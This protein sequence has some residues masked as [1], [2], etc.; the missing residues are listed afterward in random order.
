MISIK[1][2]FLFYSLCIHICIALSTAVKTEY[3]EWK[4]LNNPDDSPAHT[5]D[6]EFDDK[7]VQDTTESDKSF[8]KATEIVTENDLCK[9]LQCKPHQVCLLE[10]DDVAVCISKRKLNAKENAMK[11]SVSKKPKTKELKTESLFWEKGEKEDPVPSE[12]PNPC[13]PCPV[14]KPDFVC[15]S[16]NHTYSSVCRLEFRNCMHKVSVKVNCKGFCP[17]KTIKN[18]VDKSKEWQMKDR[19]NRYM[20]KYQNTVK[21]PAAVQKAL[22]K[23]HSINKIV[24]N[25]NILSNKDVTTISTDTMQKPSK[26]FQS[27]KISTPI[28]EKSC[29]ENELKAMGDRLLDWF[30]VVMADHRRGQSRR[31]SFR[32]SHTQLPDCKPEVSWMFQ[33]LD[34]DGDLKLSLQELYDLENDDQEH[35]LRPYLLDCDVERD[36]VLSPY[37]WCSCFDKSQRPCAAA[38][39]RIP[40]GLIGGYKPL[41]DSDGYYLPTQCHNGSGTCWCVDRHGVEFTN[42]R[43]R[44]RPDCDGL[45]KRGQYHREDNKTKKQEDEKVEKEIS[46]FVEG[47]LKN[48]QQQHRDENQDNDQEDDS[49]EEGSAD[50]PLDF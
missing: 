14:L 40:Q 1:A 10:D 46:S 25:P 11:Y 6:F 16:D 3:S 32:L 5:W 27:N 8:L 47:L 48:G 15:G 28:V 30:S 45:L 9:N 19:W 39:R 42:T 23:S 18:D 38:L 20:N 2:G 17:C 4:N 33:H 29:N 7:Q 24:K 36:L 13:I 34:T 35:C 41:C 49:E 26:A 21:K 37:E 50:R 12:N 44:G 43:R 31:R 22:K